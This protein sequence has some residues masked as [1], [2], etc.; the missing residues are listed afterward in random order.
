MKNSVE[1]R[2]AATI[3][4]LDGRLD[5]I[6]AP[7]FE[8]LCTDLLTQGEIFLVADFDQVAYV[9]SA[10]L[11]S[12]LA[13]AKRLKAVGGRIALCGLQPMVEQ[14]FSLSGFTSI[15]PIFKTADEALAAVR[16]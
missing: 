15:I 6:A 12:V 10:G 5:V 2:D 3:I 1:K 13:T 4:Q 7:E 16:G 9:S 14:I 11:R 8:Q